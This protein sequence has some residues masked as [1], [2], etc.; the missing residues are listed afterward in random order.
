M[1][2]LFIVL[3][4]LCFWAYLVHS[5]VAV[6]LLEYVNYIEHY[7][8][9]REKGEKVNI[10]HSWQSDRVSSRFMLFELS[11]HSD[12]HLK[13]SKPYYTLESHREAYV[14]PSGYFGM[15]YIALIPPLWF[16]MV[17]PII[18][19]HTAHKNH[20]LPDEKIPAIKPSSI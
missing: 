4:K 7:G 19:K 9:E 17:N 2:V 14:L 10:H 16:R 8:L 18:R 5:V 15:F 13:A 11:R 1:L 6:I 3:G 12:H 20:L